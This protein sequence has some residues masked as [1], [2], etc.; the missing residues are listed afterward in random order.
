MRD[1]QLMMAFMIYYLITALALM[2]SF[3]CKVAHMPANL[4]FQI[5]ILASDLLVRLT[6]PISEVEYEYMMN[7]PIPFKGLEGEEVTIDYQR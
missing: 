2:L 7:N 4:A 3:I 5:L 6:I 1:V